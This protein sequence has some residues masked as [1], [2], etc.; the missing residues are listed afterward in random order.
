M[1]ST[2]KDKKKIGLMGGTFNPIHVGHL[3]LA[4][5]AYE[6]FELDEVWFM[7]NKNPPHKQGKFIVEDTI[8]AKMVELSI[9]NNPHFKLCTVELEREG[10]S[11]S[12]DT[13][14]FLTKEYPQVEFY[15][16][17]GADSLFQI[18]AWKNPD[19]F[20]HLAH[21]VATTRGEKDKEMVL[22][23]ITKV[24]KRYDTDISYLSMPCIDISSNL[25]RDLMERQQSIRY[26]VT[27]DVYTYIME[28]QL[29]KR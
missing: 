8:R 6:Q 22:D 26:Y 25:I 2:T 5:A 18:S 7:P 23:Q 11:Y 17:I 29:Y 12:V 19:I 9:H 24:N 27:D 21:F 28:H 14:T 3:M 16:I 13:L 4:E 20:L 15:F 1:S 10:K